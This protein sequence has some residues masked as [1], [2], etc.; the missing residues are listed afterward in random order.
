MSSNLTAFELKPFDLRLF[1]QGFKFDVFSVS[2]LYLQV[3][4][5]NPEIEAFPLESHKNKTKTT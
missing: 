3:I 1:G 4:G 2:F 5:N